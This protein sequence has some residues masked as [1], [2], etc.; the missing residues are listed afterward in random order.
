MTIATN[1]RLNREQIIRGCEVLIDD[2][3]T[4]EALAERVDDE[5]GIATIR[6]ETLRTINDSERLGVHVVDA[7]SNELA[8]VGLGHYPESLPTSKSKVVLLYLSK[9]VLAKVLKHLSDIQEDSDVK[10]HQLTEDQAKRQIAEI[11][12]ILGRGT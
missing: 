6:M 12:K 1:L 11:R 2:V 8:D 4:Y 10:I 9:T 3:D 5:G 7:I